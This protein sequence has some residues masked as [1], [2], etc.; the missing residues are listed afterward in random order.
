[1]TDDRQRDA[2][3]YLRD[4]FAMQAMGIV[5]DIDFY[6]VGG[7][8]DFAS[9]CYDLADAMMDERARRD[10]MPTLEFNPSQ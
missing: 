2:D 1:M 3:R 9:E 7:R 5:E 4:M 6:T 10:Q 8:E